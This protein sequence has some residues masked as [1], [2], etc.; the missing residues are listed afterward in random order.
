M[1]KRFRIISALLAATLSMSI[2][3]TA[4]ATQP[5]NNQNTQSSQSN[6]V[7][8]VSTVADLNNLRDRSNN[9]E[10][11]EGKTIILENDINITKDGT[12]DGEP[13][14]F[15]SI[16]KCLDLA[17]YNDD[18]GFKGIFDGNGKTLHFNATNSNIFG[19]IGKGG[20][21]KNLKITGRFEGD[22]D[23]AIMASSNSGTIDNCQMN[24]TA[25]CTTVSA[26]G[27]CNNNSKHGTIQ[28]CEVKGNFSTNDMSCTGICNLNWGTI[29]SC[30]V[31]GKLTNC[32]NLT[33]KEYESFMVPETGGI[34]SFNIGL[35]KNCQVE[36][37]LQSVYEGKFEG[38][39]G[40][41]VSTNNGL[42]E[43]STFSGTI[44]GEYSGGITSANYGI[45]KSC[46][47]INA[48]I[49]GPRAAEFTWLNMWCD[50]EENEGK[51]SCKYDTYEAIQNQPLGVIEN[52]EFEGTVINSKPKRIAAFE[53]VLN[54]INLVPQI[55]NCKI[56][57][58]NI[59]RETDNWHKGDK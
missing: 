10:T 39:A 27:V 42:I 1:N 35:I 26:V 14:E 36:A 23:G 57:G 4:N 48:K 33:D 54:E 52:C 17:E 8:K 5:K 13:V 50:C 30:K 45:V 29:K 3:L 53:N 32:I 55:I 19:T 7:I 44:A 49:E 6:S 40:G 20:V 9:G 47:A 16:F 24:V 43:N 58:K 41:V 59:N 21:I 11:F 38:S 46:K 2:T 34:A 56:N 31:S 28:N 22:L 18:V 12:K 15:K 25:I 51:Y 37:E